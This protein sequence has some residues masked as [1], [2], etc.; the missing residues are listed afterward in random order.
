MPCSS[1][2]LGRYVLV[3]LEALKNVQEDPSWLQVNE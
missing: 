3:K 1:S 2:G